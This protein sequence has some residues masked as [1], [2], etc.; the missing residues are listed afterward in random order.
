MDS[1]LIGIYI[2]GLR[3]VA[4]G[5]HGIFRHALLEEVGLPVQGDRFH[6][7]EGIFRLVELWVSQGREQVVRDELY[8]LAHH[9]LVHPFQVAGERLVH[10]SQL[11]VYRFA[12]NVFHNGLL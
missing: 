8:I 11:H 2:K 7:R 5:S 3:L 10:E 6:K 12:N 4:H 9:L 1:T